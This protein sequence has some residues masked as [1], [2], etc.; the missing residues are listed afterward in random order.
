MALKGSLPAGHPTDSIVGQCPAI[1]ALRAQIRHLSAFDT[2]G[3]P[4]VPTLL[5]HGE[6]GTGKGLVA[7]AIHESGP[8]ASGPLIEVNCAAIPDGLLEA[9]L[10]GF[11]AGAFTDAKRAKPGLF[12]AAG[13]G[14]LFLDEI[15]ALPLTLQTKFLNALEGK[16]IRRLGAV[17]DLSVDVKLIAATHADLGEAVGAGRFRA[18]LYHRLAVVLLQLPP[19]RARGDDILTL[20]QH[21]LRRYADAHGRPARRV[22]GAAEAWLLGYDWPGNVRELSHLMER[23]TL[24]SAEA[25]LAPDTLERL[26]LPRPALSPKPKSAPAGGVLEPR[27]DPVRIQQALV[28]AEGNVLRAARLLGLS[29]S[30]LRHR[31]Y[32]YGIDRPSREALAQLLGRPTQEE[33]SLPTALPLQQRGPAQP[34]LQ[35]Q[36]YAKDRPADRAKPTAASGWAQKPVVVLAISITFPKTGALEAPRYE[37]WTVAAHWEQH[38][39]DKVGGLGGVLLQR[40]PSLVLVVFGIPQTL[41]QLP[42]RAAHAALAIR[43]LV[44]EGTGSAERAAC[45][46][47]RLGVHAGTVLVDTLSNALFGAGFLYL[48]KGDLRNAIPM[49]ERC[50]YAYPDAC[51]GR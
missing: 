6:T 44:A 5:L 33:A 16:R 13:G 30:A 45:P 8:R 18:D 26:C 29:R 15:E 24:L 49:L 2:V 27:D 10:F 46:E 17:R 23:V 39:V 32:R 11:E 3:N 48:R 25:I 4:Y 40:S 12:E 19:L 31:M 50:L 14:T 7:H 42:Q 41:E 38:I 9:E 21:F 35:D 22:S 43:Q 34:P 36:G 37:P 28:Q 47:V 20:A 51:Q 1:Q